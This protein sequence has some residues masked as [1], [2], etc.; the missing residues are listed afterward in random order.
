MTNL[1]E[2]DSFNQLVDD[3]IALYGSTIVHLP[4]ECP[5][6]RTY[7]NFERHPICWFCGARGV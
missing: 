3:S 7:N 6:C 5:H 4:T 1:S 2:T